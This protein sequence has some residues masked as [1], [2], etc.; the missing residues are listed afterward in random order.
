MSTREPPAAILFDVGNTLIELD[1]VEMVSVARQ[2]GVHVTVDEMRSSEQRAR[3]SFDE[4]MAAPGAS[5]E[6]EAAFELYLEAAF[7]GCG[8]DDGW[9]PLIPR[10]A[11]LWRVPIEG[12]KESLAALSSLGFR[13]AAVSNSDGHVEELLTE[14]E[15]VDHLEFVVDSGK[16]GIEKPD[17]RIFQIAIDRLGVPAGE[18]LYV[19][20]L[21]H[22]DVCGARAAGLR[23][24]LLD[25]AGNRA[26]LDVDR[27]RD[28]QELV[29]SLSP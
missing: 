27:V 6:T 9:Q 25:P 28:L 2:A 23:T 18:V 29:V 15:L 24:V 21:F 10:R 4:H 16:V 19:G 7:T 3:R 22:V 20:D 12:S 14:L 26:D 13:L 5:T 1:H 8:A 11:E 17:P